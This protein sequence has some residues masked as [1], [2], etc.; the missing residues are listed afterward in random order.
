MNESFVFSGRHVVLDRKWSQLGLV[1]CLPLLPSSTVERDF[2]TVTSSS[3]IVLGIE[4]PKLKSVFCRFLKV[5]SSR[6]RAHLTV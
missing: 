1:T 4:F 5:V 6:I 3:E 2:R